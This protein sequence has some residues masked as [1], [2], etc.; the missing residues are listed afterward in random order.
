MGGASMIKFKNS[1]QLKSF[2]K[3]EADRLN[4]SISNVYHT[5]AARK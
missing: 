2:M 3:K 1:N 5:F 4:I